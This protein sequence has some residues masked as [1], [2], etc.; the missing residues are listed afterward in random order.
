MRSPGEKKS[1]WKEKTLI[2]FGTAYYITRVNE[3]SRGKEVVMEGKNLIYQCDI[4]IVATNL[5]EDNNEFPYEATNICR[6]EI[7][8]YLYSIRSNIKFHFYGPISFQELYPD[9]YKGFVTYNNCK[10]IFSNSKINLSIHPLIYEL[11][12]HNCEKEYFSERVPQIL[13]CKGLLMTNSYFHHLLKPDID[14]IHINKD[15]YKEKI[16]EI[17][18]NSHT[19]DKIRF[20]GYQKGLLYYQWNNWAIKIH[21]ILNYTD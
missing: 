19:Y 7:V 6:Y 10:K 17:I 1:L 12:D 11:N 18:N 9:C 4:S 5:Y 2:S 16:N 13:G 3:V 21:N 15:N 8:N 14:Y 20:N